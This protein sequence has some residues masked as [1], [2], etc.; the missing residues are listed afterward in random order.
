MGLKD[1]ICE[2]DGFVLLVGSVLFFKVL[3]VVYSKDSVD[4]N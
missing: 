3:R 4:L 1:L 2:V